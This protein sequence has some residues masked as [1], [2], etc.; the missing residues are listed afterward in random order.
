MRGIIREGKINMFQSITD[1]W[2]KQRSSVE[3]DANGMSLMLKLSGVKEGT[4]VPAST[5]VTALLWEQYGLDLLHPEV[6]RW[7]EKN[8]PDVKYAVARNKF[9]N[10]DNRH[11]ENFRVGRNG[12]LKVHLSLYVDDRLRKVSSDYICWQVECSMEP[13][14]GK[15]G[16][17]TKLL[18]NY[19]GSKSE[20]GYFAYQ[21]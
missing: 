19:T 12:I 2:C 13:Q 3:L 21:N 18:N 11:R 4:L 20:N 6:S 14:K 8:A 5:V 10:G 17:M 15:V 16:S 1:F 7:L 9:A